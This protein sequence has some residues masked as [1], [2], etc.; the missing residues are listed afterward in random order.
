MQAASAVAEV[1][2]MLT[3]VLM[4]TFILTLRAF[5]GFVFMTA[6]CLADLSVDANVK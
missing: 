4:E 5:I 6:V 1:L 3:A 2:T